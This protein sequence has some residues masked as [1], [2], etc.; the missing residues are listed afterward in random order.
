MNFSQLVSLATCLA[1]NGILCLRFTCKGM[2]ISY[3]V[4]AYKAVLEYLRSSKDYKV[5]G[6]FLGGRSMGSCAAA[7]I[8]R[9][10]CSSCED[11]F[12]QGLICLSYPLHP[13]KQLSNLRT[14]DL[15][16]VKQ[17]VLFV[18]GSAD[19]MCK[20]SLLEDT[21]RRMVAPTKIYWLKGGSH[22]ME[23][24]GQTRDDTMTEINLQVLSWIEEII[25][26]AESN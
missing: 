4:K 9:Q 1:T 24:K 26:K 12:V 22:G 17:P 11:S 3:R 8:A 25:R 19:E 20:K 23:V 21:L 10:S 13:P 18:S 2:N 14:D 6:L 16:L 7:C 15:L 5:N